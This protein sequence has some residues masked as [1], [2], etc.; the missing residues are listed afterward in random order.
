[1]NFRAAIRSNKRFFMAAFVLKNSIAFRSRDCL[2]STW[3]NLVITCPAVTIYTFKVFIIQR[4]R[5]RMINKGP[6][7]RPFLKAEK[8]F[9]PIWDPGIQ[10]S[11][12]SWCFQHHY[13]NR[14]QFYYWQRLALFCFNVC[15]SALQQCCVVLAWQKFRF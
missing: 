2:R 7:I 5:R 15:V 3:Q 11:F 1:M 6:D 4:R 12:S 8:G 10:V 13:S 9:L 14:S